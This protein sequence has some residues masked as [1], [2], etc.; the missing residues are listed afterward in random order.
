MLGKFRK[1]ENAT[2]PID[3]LIMGLGNPGEEYAGTRHNAGYE[4]VDRLAEAVGVRYWKNEA[5]C[6][7]GEG[8]FESLR[9][10]LAKPGS[11]MNTS[12]GPVSKLMKRRGITP[13]RLIVVHDELDIPAA[14]LRVKNGGGHAGHRGL[15]SIVEAL[16]TRDWLRVRIGIGRPPGRM[17]PSD[18]VLTR[19]RGDDALAFANTADR[20]AEAVL[21]LMTAGFE[22]TRQKYHGA[23]ARAAAAKAKD[24]AAS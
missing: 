5:G 13:D 15:R 20:G 1:T 3:Y 2:Q 10:L 14:T 11:F 17:D 23:E 19:P 16:G 6:E 22:P 24:G 9:V 21:S 7:V 18:F 8:T 4:V 12:G